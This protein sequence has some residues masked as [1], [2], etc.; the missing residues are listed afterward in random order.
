MTRTFRPGAVGALMDELERATGELSSLIATLD[1]EAFSKVRDAAAP[2]PDCRSIQTV[3]RHVVRSG[4]AY[5]NYIRKEFSIQSQLEEPPLSSAAEAGGELRRML[6][7]MSAT[8]EGR[9]QMS[10]PEVFATRIESRW[11]QL[12]D[13]E[14]LL[15][16]AIV[17]VLRHRRQIERFLA[18]ESAVSGKS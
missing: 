6:Q 2:D 3:T 13:L 17:H 9:W 8:L 16:H 5:A 15:E 12:Y 14:Q 7:Y 1:E 4:F 18:K 10:E 11:G